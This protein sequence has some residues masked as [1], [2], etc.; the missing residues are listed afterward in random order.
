MVAL[1]DDH[2]A[3]W[4][5]DELDHFPEGWQV[6]ILD[7]TLVVD[8]NPETRAPWTAD[9]LDRFPESNRF[10]VIDGR[11]YV[12][13]QPNLLHQYVA[14]ELRALLTAQLGDEL[15]VVREIGVSMTRSLLGPDISLVKRSDVQ[16]KAKEQPASAAVLVIEVASPTTRRKDRRIK[17]EK[18]AEAGIPGYWRVELDPTT[19][20]AYALRDGGYVELGTWA[21]GETVV[22]DEPV[23]VRFDP[24]TLL[25]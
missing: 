20:I 18:Y 24:A 19:V 17:F 7:G 22:V 21:E 13:A 15:V 10:E 9:D 1:L 5:V 23:R 11:L 4:T 25:P 16:W 6:E 12:N 2:F 14:D 8:H 3:P